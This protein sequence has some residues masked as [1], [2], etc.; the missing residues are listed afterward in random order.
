MKILLI[1]FSSIGDIVLTSPVSR[2]LKNQLGAEVHYLTKKIFS[3]L[4]QP[5]P[6]IDKVYAI[7]KDIKEVLSDLKAERYD[8]IL[9][10]HHNLRSLRVKWAL[11]RPVKAF[12]K[13]N[14]EKWL[15]VHTGLNTMPNSHIVHRY[16]AT[17]KHLGVEYDGLGLDHYIPNEAIV[18][19]ECHSPLLKPGQYTAFV[20]G[21][22][23]ATK[24]MPR[25]KMVEIC[26]QLQHPIAILGGK[27]EAED[28]QFLAEHT[29]GMA[30]N[31]CGQLSI[32]QSA[33]VVGQSAVVLTHDT[34]L[35]HIAAALRKRVISVWGSTVPQFGMYPF[36]PD[37]V[38]QN[39]AM[40]ILGLSCRPCSKIGHKS[41]PKGHFS[42]MRDLDSQQIS[43]TVDGAYDIQER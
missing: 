38:E 28:G 41:C 22:T 35:M 9:D 18:D 11:G 40:E 30:V 20:I 12:N 13:L 25:E 23:H 37:G 17:A 21:A 39:S 36:Y 33:S 5:N 24:R 43:A 34:G 8:L 27:A 3:G 14:V 7:D 26:R 1:R 16:L 15:L 29:G 32:Q 19:V 2:C 42:C 4:I 31:L 10:L 6:T